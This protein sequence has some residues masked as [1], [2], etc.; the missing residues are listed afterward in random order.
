MACSKGCPTAAVVFGVPGCV[1]LRRSGTARGGASSCR[2]AYVTTGHDAIGQGQ[3][4]SRQRTR[5]RTRLAGVES[6][7]IDEHAW[8]P[9]KIGSSGRAARSRAGWI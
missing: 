2:S 3:I 5:A 9:G 7:G 4:R 6:L 1:S 8:R